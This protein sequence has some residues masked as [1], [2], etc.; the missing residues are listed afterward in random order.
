MT[1]RLLDELMIELIGEDSLKLIK[2]I[3]SRFNVS[4]FL[5]A[6]KLKISINQVRNILYRLQ[7]YNLVTFTRKKDKKKG[8]YI[9]YWTFNL[10]RARELL[11]ESK[12]NKLERFSKRLDRELH[13]SFYVCPNSCIRMDEDTA[14]S[15]E[16]KCQECGTILAKEDNSKIIDQIKKEIV[17]LKDEL[18]QKETKRK[19]V[20][21]KV[22]KI[23]KSKKF[24]KKNL[25]RKK[26]HQKKL[27][28]K[29]SSKRTSNKIVKKKNLF[30]KK[31][32]QK[33]PLKK[34]SRKKTKKIKK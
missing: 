18:K 3:K 26:L 24:T 9:Y 7:N 30:R 27:L 11:L 1:D 20:K 4:E 16:Y 8:W 13:N 22:A 32:H 19:K 34:R 17:I 15:Y 28:G 33:E 5:I 23:K 14:M 29:V 31:L 25:F 12:K 10:K 21:K 6:E 2:L